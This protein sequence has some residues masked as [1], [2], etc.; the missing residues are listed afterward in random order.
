MKKPAR[1]GQVSVLWGYRPRPA[2]T[3]DRAS[4]ARVECA[5]TDRDGMRFRDGVA[6]HLPRIGGLVVAIVVFGI[7][8]WIG[9][10][11]IDRVAR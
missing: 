7:L 6:H 11:A 4:W 5:M 10:E 3:Y 2:S 8:F 1:S 9:M